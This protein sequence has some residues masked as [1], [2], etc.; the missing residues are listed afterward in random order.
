MRATI[1]ML[2]KQPLHIICILL[3]ILFGVQILNTITAGL[4]SN[5]GIYPRYINGLIGIPLAPFI[6]HSWQ[7][8][9]SNA[10]PLAV[11]AFIVLQQG[12]KRFTLWLFASEG[13]HAGASTLVFGLIGYIICNAIFSRNIFNLMLAAIICFLYASVIYSLTQF[14]PGVS[15]SSH[16]FGF[17]AGCIA[18]KLFL[19]KQQKS[20]A[21]Y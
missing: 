5:F 19:S 21:H 11:L 1:D 8:L 4:V 10:A 18:G 16:F 12:L 6:H 20:Q 13:F 3:V 7:H 9:L 14:V 15:W 17:I 2:I